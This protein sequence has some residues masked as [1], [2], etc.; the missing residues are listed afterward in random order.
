MIE[1]AKFTYSLLG[2]AFEK[3]TKEHVKAIK[4]LNISD[5]A[6]ELKQIEGTFSQNVL[7]NLINNK[8]KTMIE[9]Q[10]SIQLDKLDYKN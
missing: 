7:N 3:Q 2:K 9:L 10:N 8:L 5:K 6:N 4:Y 1:Q